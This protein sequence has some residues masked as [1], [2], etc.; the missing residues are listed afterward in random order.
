MRPAA[1]AQVRAGHPWVFAESI[2]EQNRPGEAGELAV[3]Y[4][5]QDRFLAVGLCD[6]QSPIRIRV[7]HGGAPANIDLAWFRDRLEEA[8]A[9]RSSVFSEQTNG[10]RWIN[11][12]SDRF[13]ALVL[14]RYDGTLVI[15][16]YSE[17][18]FRW[19]EQI[20]ALVLDRFAPAR[21]VLRL[22][23]N[24]Q[25]P[26]SKQNL[27]DGQV[28][29]GPAIAG[30]VHFLENGLRFEADVVRG[31]KTGFFLDQR[32]NRRAIGELAQ[33]KDV[34]NAFSFSGGFSLYAARGGARSVTD[35]DISAHALESSRR[36]F[37][38]N[39]NAAM[40]ACRHELVQAD[41]FEWL[42]TRRT[43]M[44]DLIVLDPPSLA[45]RQ[46]ERAGALQAYES[47][48]ASGAGLA[49][50]GA[51]LV[52][53]SCSAHVRAGEFFRTVENAV[54]RTGRLAQVLEQTREPADHHATFP[55]AE[56]LKAVFLQLR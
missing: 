53:C 8:A 10:G 25:G 27:A 51:I 1:E 3:I 32:E 31:Q 2:R 18:W 42:R 48:A 26:A 15:K 19:L 11:G 40:R 30:P 34:L 4:D 52:C 44:Y 21:L 22:S 13:P 5:R 45:K 7:L 38:L 54:R 33:G 47:L 6:P 36:N 37:A 20:R 35:V 12:E 43:E 23:R 41:V 28:L 14:D 39:D 16:L 46:C 24:V 49:R 56:Y 17:I 55:E 29:F 9:R 50:P